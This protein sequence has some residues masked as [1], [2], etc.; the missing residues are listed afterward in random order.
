MV[1]RDFLFTTPT[2]TSP[3]S[4]QASCTMGTRSLSKEYNGHGMAMN[5]HLYPV[6]RSTMGR[7]TSTTTS[8]PSS[9]FMG[10]HLSLVLLSNTVSLVS[11]FN[12]VTYTHIHCVYW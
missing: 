8:V 1:A 3:V 5:T 7:V 11:Y 2:P 6:L 10:Q 9:L 12:L 4:K